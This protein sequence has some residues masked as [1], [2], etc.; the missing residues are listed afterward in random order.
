MAHEQEKAELKTG[1][2]LRNG[3]GALA[4]LPRRADNF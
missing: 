1:N 4:Y 3:E 2:A